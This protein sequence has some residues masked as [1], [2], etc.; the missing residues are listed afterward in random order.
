MVVACYDVNVNERSGRLCVSEN[1]I[2]EHHKK[3]MTAHYSLR[4]VPYWPSEQR[5]EEPNESTKSPD[6]YNDACHPKRD[7][8]GVS[9]EEDPWHECVCVAP[10][11]RRPLAAVAVCW[12]K[13]PQQ[14]RLPSSHLF[15]FAS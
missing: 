2:Q 8:V 9:I 6:G 10:W 7:N 3:T 4:L 12:T 5:K 13:N 11:R 1:Y 14:W 15:R